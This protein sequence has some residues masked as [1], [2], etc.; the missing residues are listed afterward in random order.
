MTAHAGSSV[1]EL[2]LELMDLVTLAMPQPLYEGVVS[3]V[4]N[5]DGRRPALSDLDGKAHV[6]APKCV[7][8]GHN[9]NHVLDAINSILADI[10][11]ATDAAAQL[12]VRHG[13][14]EWRDAADGSRD[15]LLIETQPDAAPVVRVRRTFTDDEL[16]FLL[17]TPALF[18][19]LHRTEAS[20][21][22]QQQALDEALRGVEKFKIDMESGR[23]V[24]SGAGIADQPWRFELVGSHLHEKGD[25]GS[26]GSS[27]FLW[28]FAND[29]VG[30]PLKAG[31]ARLRDACEKRVGMRLFV[32]PDLG[33]PEPMFHRLAMHAAVEMAAF[34]LYR[35]PFA[36]RSGTGAMY[37]ALRAA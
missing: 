23:I 10:G 21:L 4:P 29:E 18:A 26:M 9:D 20:A 27:R 24:F 30:M 14:I 35:A 3:F 34:A 36:S 25:N 8:L 7:A 33:G 37:L 31:T 1:D 5:E 16:R 2:L 19:E 28:A 13:R 12:R 32:E 15:V 22:R 17:F 11:D 6:D